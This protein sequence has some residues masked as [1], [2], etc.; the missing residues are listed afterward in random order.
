M[1]TIR[2]N[3][4]LL[5][6]TATVIFVQYYELWNVLCNWKNEFTA[7]EFSSTFASPS[8]NK[9]LYDMT[10][11]GFLERTGWGQYRVNSQREYLLKKQDVSRG[12]EL[13]ERASMRYSFTDV[14]SVFLWTRGAYQVGRFFGFY[15]V[16]FKVEENEVNKWEKFYRKKGIM[17]HVEG[18]DLHRTLFGIF[19]V[20]H[21]S[22]EFE[23][24][25]LEGKPVDPLKETV[26]FCKNKIYLYEPA[27][28][29]LN[30]M[31]KLGMDT[32]YSEKATNT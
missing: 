30:E 27:L 19:S 31:Y 22:E 12:Y 20:I 1:R 29:M 26:E 15:P 3:K 2:C 8:S 28:E 21:P 14:D 16:H 10:S 17:V 13:P 32:Q 11:K 9:V 24:E 25:E 23:S 5:I 18:R 4:Q 6:I 7:K